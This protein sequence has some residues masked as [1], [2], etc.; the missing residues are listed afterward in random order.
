M[1]SQCVTVR[2]SVEGLGD[3]VD[4]REVDT[5]DRQT[6][7]FWGISNGVFVEGKPY[8]RYEPPLTSEVLRLG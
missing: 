6:M 7:L 3:I 2:D 1:C 5:A 8:R 4:H